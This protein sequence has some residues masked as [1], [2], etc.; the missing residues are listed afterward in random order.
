MTTSPCRRKLSLME[1]AGTRAPK[2]W[3]IYHAEEDPERAEAV[4]EILKRLNHKEIKESL[5][6]N[7][8]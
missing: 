5:S 1:E 2:R 7:N 6:E 3:P 4:E 8:D